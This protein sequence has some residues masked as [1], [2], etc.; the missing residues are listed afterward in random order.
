MANVTALSTNTD[1][2]PAIA[3]I[4]TVQAGATMRPALYATEFMTTAA[5]LS[6]AWSGTSAGINADW[7][8]RASVNIS[9][10]RNAPINRETCDRLCVICKIAIT[11]VIAAE[12]T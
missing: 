12:A 3:T 11:A 8:G 7:A 5:L 2:K 1:P 10:T 4:S 9:P 6:A